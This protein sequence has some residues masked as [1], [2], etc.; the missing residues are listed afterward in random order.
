MGL[1]DTY[2]PTW[3][4]GPRLAYEGT[5]DKS[6]LSLNFKS[7]ISQMETSSGPAFIYIQ[8]QRQRDPN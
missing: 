7:C 8:Y 6:S 3:S 1:I 4:V 2:Q 5:K